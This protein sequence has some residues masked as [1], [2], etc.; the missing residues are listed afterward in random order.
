MVL[1]KLRSA[2]RRTLGKEQCIEPTQVGNLAFLHFGEA[3]VITMY[4]K[5]LLRAAQIILAIRPNEH[6]NH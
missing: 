1:G 2:P 5:E 6:E 3:V 4:P